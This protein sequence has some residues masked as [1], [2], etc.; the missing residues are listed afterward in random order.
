[1]S[2]HVYYRRPLAQFA[3]RSTVPAPTPRP[4]FD[5]Q[6]VAQVLLAVRTAREGH[7]AGAILRLAARGEVATPRAILDVLTDEMGDTVVTE[8]TVYNG[9]ADG[10][11]NGTVYRTGRGTYE[12]GLKLSEIGGTSW[13]R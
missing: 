5:A 12:L 13:T 9:I 8:R 2:S 4:R 10:I 11:A 1:M 6:T 7:V 3:R